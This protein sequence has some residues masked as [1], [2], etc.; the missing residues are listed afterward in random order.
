MTQPHTFFYD[1]TL[2][3]PT[4]LSDGFFAEEEIFP[5]VNLTGQPVMLNRFATCVL[6]FRVKSLAEETNSTVEEADA[7]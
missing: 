1:P 5:G 3:N 6:F 4:A 7:I 2:F